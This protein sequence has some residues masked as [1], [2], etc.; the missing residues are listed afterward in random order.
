MPYVTSVERRDFE[1][2]QLQA[3]Q[4]MLLEMVATRFGGVPAGGTAAVQ[5]LLASRR[6]RTPSV[7]H[8]GKPRRT[9]GR[10]AVR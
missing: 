9:Q 4:E 10:K 6:F 3:A 8:R 7:P 2:G 1:Q 5:H